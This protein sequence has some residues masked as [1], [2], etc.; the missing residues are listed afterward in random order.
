MTRSL[1][2]FDG[3]CQCERL[4]SMTFVQ[5]GGLSRD[6]FFQAYDLWTILTTM[7]RPNTN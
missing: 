3:I 2:N 5:F 6:F 1:L 4:G 7:W